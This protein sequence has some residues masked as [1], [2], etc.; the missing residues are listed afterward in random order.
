MGGGD[1][2][3]WGEAQAARITAIRL[4][5]ESEARFVFIIL[6]SR[7]YQKILTQVLKLPSLTVILSYAI[8]QTNRTLLEEEWLVSN[9]HMEQCSIRLRICT[10]DSTRRWQLLRT[11]WAKN[12]R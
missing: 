3:G 4:R 12:M 5:L 2:V 7:L 1:G 8:L 11:T 6:Q 10:K 9:S